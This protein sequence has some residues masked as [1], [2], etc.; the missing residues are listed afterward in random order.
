MDLVETRLPRPG[1]PRP[2]SGIFS[3]DPASLSEHGE[4]FEIAIA[5]TGGCFTIPPDKTIAQVLAENG[6]LVPTS[7]EQG[8]CGTCLTGVLE[9][10][11]TTA[12]SSSPMT[13]SAR[14][15]G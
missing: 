3:A 10:V 2:S 7:C 14:A 13:K 15:T 9:G 1:S 5:S 6:T 8:V 11:P 4:S 12:T